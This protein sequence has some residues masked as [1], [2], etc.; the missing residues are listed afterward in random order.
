MAGAAT[1]EQLDWEP[2]VEEPQV[3]EI[4]QLASDELTRTR[5]KRFIGSV[6]T[7]A[8]FEVTGTIENPNLSLQ[9]AAW[10]AREGD[11]EA[12]KLVE[13][14]VCT[15]VIER[16]IKAGHIM[17]VRQKVTADGQLMQYGQTGRSIQ[18]NS[19]RYAT[20]NPKM[21]PRTE[22]EARNLF[23]IEDA[24]REGLLQD[25]VFLVIS[26][27]ADD[28]SETELR[29]EGFFVDT[30]SVA[31]QATSANADGSLTTESAF[32]A[33]KH[34][35]SAQRH[36][37]E[38]VQRLGWRLGVDFSNKSAAEIID[39]PL[40][41]PKALMPNGVIDLV[42]LYD[43]VAGGTFFGQD[44]Q[45]QNYLAYAEQCTQRER[46]LEPTVQE[47]VAQFIAEADNFHEPLD[48]TRRLHELS[49][50]ALVRRALYDE[51]IGTTVFGIESAEYIQAA[52]HYLEQGDM[53]R[54]GQFMA[55]AIDTADS[56]SCPGSARSLGNGNL[57]DKEV[58]SA[59][60][61]DCEF[62][63]KECPLCHKK[64]VKTVVKKLTSGKKYIKG[65]D[66]GCVK[67]A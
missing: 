37:G 8:S 52:R 58:S 26:R 5:A 31:L 62:T 48:A 21:R 43:E 9:D 56:S 41:I 61:G 6:V 19:L 59:E 65:I 38:T 32:V 27:A 29:K 67:V 53:D 54:V 42:R 1:A 11:P 7:G 60:D 12:R 4:P 3:Y 18:A 16:T 36:D 30:M 24:N 2:Y 20:Q 34:D 25:H 40:L 28:M 50:A 39:T 63:S 33:G 45:R 23:R 14:N 55:K 10:R 47:I 57:S 64:N 51:A 66:C 22:A 49:E 35:H 46:E 15:D 13:M 44:K 17:N